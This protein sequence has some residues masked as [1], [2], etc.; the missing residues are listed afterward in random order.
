VADLY[1]DGQKV[2][3]AMMPTNFITRRL[4]IFWKYP[5]ENKKHTVKVKLANP[6]GASYFGNMECV[7]YSQKPA[8]ATK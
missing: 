6:K 2:E 1:L 7:I 3:T 4:D 5:L 8:L